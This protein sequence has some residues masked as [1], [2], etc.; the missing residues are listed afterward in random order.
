MV[1]K[2]YDSELEDEKYKNLKEQLKTHD[3]RL[4]N[5]GERL[6]N[7]EKHDAAADERIDHLCE[8]IKDLVVTLRWGIGVLGTAFLGIFVYLLELH[9]K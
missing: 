7:L 9:L 8:Q 4:N 5:H 1:A 2:G 6:K 3:N